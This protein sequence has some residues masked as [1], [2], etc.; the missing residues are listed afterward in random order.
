MATSV[1]AQKWRPTTFDEVVGQSHVTTTLK[2]AL[3]QNYLHHAYLFTGTRGVGKTTIARI[4]AKALNCR[5]GITDQ[6]CGTC[7]HCLEITQGNF[8]DLLEIDAASRT[9]VE[10]T[11]ELLSNAQYAPNKGRFKIYLIDEVHML[12]KHSFNALL[13]TLEE[14]PAHI[15]FLLATT[16]PKALPATVLS[17]CLQFHLTH[18]AEKDIT[19]QLAHILTQEKIPFEMPALS[20]ITQGAKGSMRDALS[21][22]NQGVSY[23]NGHIKLSDMQSMLNVIDTQLIQQLLQKCI[24]QD[25]NQLMQLIDTVDHQGID[26]A[27]LLDDFITLL[28]DIAVTQV[29]NK[30]TNSTCIQ[31]FAKQLTAA[32][33]QWLYEA[34]LLD[35]KHFYLHPSSKI[36][37]K[38]LF[39]K[40]LNFREANT[41][42]TQ[43][44]KQPASAQHA[45]TKPAL[46]KKTELKKVTPPKAGD[47]LTARWL[48]LLPKLKITGVAQMLLQ[49]CQPL[50]FSKQCLHL[51]LHMQQKPLLQ[52][53]YIK[54]IETALFEH[55]KKHIPIKITLTEKL[56]P[57]TPHNRMEQ[58]KQQKQ[59]KA[60]DYLAKDTQVQ[61]M[62][63]KL[64][65]TIVDDS[66]EL[67]ND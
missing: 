9:K 18:I 31:S 23:G 54:R 5:T 26:G 49:Y 17:R 11:R 39:L 13:K 15:K 29:I 10:D 66:V 53:T 22:L 43:S 34:A 51:E 27:H 14:P 16:E 42:A 28:H 40:L 4:L 48:N 56:L 35:K 67:L 50:S 52:P 38:V 65:A 36:G 7:D 1:I 3:K 12:S 20:L 63:E 61:A 58:L 44:V 37:L 32:E 2:N 45:K 57:H 33:V 21:L 6:P 8:I 47:D 59:Q 60:Q 55:L 30:H 41:K 25:A 64:G 62:K 46:S 24:E 19:G